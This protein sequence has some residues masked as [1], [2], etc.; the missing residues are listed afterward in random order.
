MWRHKKSGAIS[1]TSNDF[2]KSCV[3]KQNKKQMEGPQE[4]KWGGGAGD[5]A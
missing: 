3:Q 1:A 4:T 5:E 2:R